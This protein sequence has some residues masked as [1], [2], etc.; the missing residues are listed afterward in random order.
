ML[1]RPVEARDSTEWLRMRQT[2]WTDDDTLELIFHPFQ[3][4]TKFEKS[5][6]SQGDQLTSSN[7]S[8]LSQAVRALQDDSL[9]ISR[10]S[11][12]RASHA[13]FEECF[14]VGIFAFGMRIEVFLYVSYT[15][16][17]K[18]LSNRGR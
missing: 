14:E 16:D 8:C 11:P 10:I 15:V 2:L 6:M 3:T 9:P 5:T 18:A 7:G 1:I 13:R 17:R 4:R 12:T